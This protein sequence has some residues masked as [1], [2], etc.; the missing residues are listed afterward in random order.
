MNR[1]DEIEARLNLPPVC[2]AMHIAG[3]QCDSCI[4]HATAMMALAITSP[5]DLALL[6]G[7]V[8]EMAESTCAIVELVNVGLIDR[9]GLESQ[10][11]H[12]RICRRC[13]TLRKLEAAK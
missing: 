6:S 4:S 10:E 8:R 13:P 12:D 7:I 1:L 3:R 5:R 9:A 2:T 11:F